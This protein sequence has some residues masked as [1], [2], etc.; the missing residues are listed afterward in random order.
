M[1]DVGIKTQTLLIQFLLLHMILFFQIVQNFHIKLL[2]VSI[3]NE[4]QDGSTQQYIAAFRPPGKPQRRNNMD[5]QSCNLIRPFLVLDTGFYHEMIITGRHITEG[6]AIGV[7]HRIPCIF[8]SFQ[9]IGI[10]HLVDQCIV[11][12]IKSNIKAILHILQPHFRLTV[13]TD[14]FFIVSHI[15]QRSKYLHFRDN[16][17]RRLTLC[18]NKIRIEVAK[19]IDGTEINLSILILSYTATHKISH[20]HIIPMVIVIEN[21]LIPQQTTDSLIGAHPDIMIRIFRY[22]TYMCIG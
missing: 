21:I 2:L 12:Y 11:P 10:L 13:N 22:S 9:H 6:Y 14:H 4:E 20:R 17:R 5:I 15:T 19:S 16:S 8:Q 7:C 3:K 18:Q 1:R